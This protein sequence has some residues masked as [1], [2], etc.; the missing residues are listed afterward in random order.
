MDKAVFCCAGRHL[1]HLAC[2]G[3]ALLRSAPSTGIKASV[4][5]RLWTSALLCRIYPP[6]CPWVP[7][8]LPCSGNR[9]AQLAA[10][11]RGVQHVG[12]PPPP[13]PFRGPSRAQK[14]AWHHTGKGHTAC[15]VI[16]PGPAAGRQHPVVRRRRADV[17]LLGLYISIA[18]VVEH[19]VFCGQAVFSVVRQ[20]FAAFQSLWAGACCR[21]GRP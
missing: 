4:P 14:R 9:P 6:G 1:H 7:R 18:V 20:W 10:V 5:H 19:A 21:C 16:R 15:S 12:R 8:K 3:Q 13:K 17:V 11:S 2:C